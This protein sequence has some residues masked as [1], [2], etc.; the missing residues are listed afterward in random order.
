MAQPGTYTG[1]IDYVCRDPTVNLY[2]RARPTDR[3]IFVSSPIT[4]TQVKTTSAVSPCNPEQRSV[5]TVSIRN[6]QKPIVSL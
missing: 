4:S 1:W 5:R 3:H 6:H 2:A